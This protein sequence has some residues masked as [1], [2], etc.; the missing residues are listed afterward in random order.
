MP[1]PT[2]STEIESTVPCEPAGQRRRHG[3]Q[4]PEDEERL[5]EAQIHGRDP[6]PAGAPVGPLAGRR[7]R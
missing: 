6:R 4:Q 3:E 7:L 5:G 1:A 2:E